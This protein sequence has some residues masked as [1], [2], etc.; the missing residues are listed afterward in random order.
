M[1]LVIILENRSIVLIALSKT[2]GSRDSTGVPMRNQKVCASFPSR[3][4]SCLLAKGYK[5]DVFRLSR[6]VSMCSSI[7]QISFF[8]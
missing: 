8:G 5:N 1:I 6:E 7:G 4:R 3:S 2:S